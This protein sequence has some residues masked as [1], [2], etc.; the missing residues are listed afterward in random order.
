MFIKNQ[1]EFKQHPIRNLIEK[2]KSY[3]IDANMMLLCKADADCGTD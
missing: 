3:F 2:F 1:L